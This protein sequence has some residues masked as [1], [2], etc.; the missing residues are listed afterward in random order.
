[1]RSQMLQVN[2]A[3]NFVSL[4]GSTLHHIDDLPYDP[5][6]FCPP[7]YSSM[8]RKQEEVRVRDLLPTPQAGS[9]PFSLQSSLEN[10]AN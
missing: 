5:Y 8:R 6:D 2:A 1:M 7:S 3:C 10:E 4:W 9:L